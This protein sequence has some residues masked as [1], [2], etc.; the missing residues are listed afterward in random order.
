MEN[1]IGNRLAENFVQY[2]KK[3]LENQFINNKV[4]IDLNKIQKSMNIFLN[5]AEIYEKMLEAK[6]KEENVMGALAYFNF[7]KDR[8]YKSFFQFQNDINSYLNQK[9]VMTYVHQDENGK[10]ELR[11]SENDVNHII[12][13]RWGNRLEY[14]VDHA[15]DILKNNLSEE[16][17]LP[18]QNTANEVEW[19]YKNFK[20][21]VLWYYNNKWMGY[22]MNKRGPINEAFVDF[23]IHDVKLTNS[24]ENDINTFMLDENYGA[25][26]ADATKGF[27]IGDVAS[28][29][30]QYAIKGQ[31]GS[32]QGWKDVKNQ[33]LK[34]KDNFNEESLK[35]TIKYFL[36]DELDRKYTPQIKEMSEETIQN[37]MEKHKRQI[38]NLIK[39]KN[40]NIKFD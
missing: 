17:N 40:I 6:K 13:G 10:R 36:E 32:P 30:I 1:N 28:N 31:Y 3:Q 16:E 19:R 5:E 2:S 7:Q 20:K 29:G 15:Y 8:L 14:S 25:I 11:I 39:N 9:I 34:I 22:H 27:V 4:S 33:F 37:Y 26:K 38:S 23:Y 12:R 18:L 24:L 21:N 35:N